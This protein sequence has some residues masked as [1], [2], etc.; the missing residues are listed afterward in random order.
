MHKMHK[1][2]TLVAVLALLGSALAQTITFATWGG[3][4]DLDIYEEL[5]ADFEAANPGVTV[6]VNHIPSAGDYEQNLATLIAAGNAPDVFFINNISMPGFA[7]QGAFMS[8]EDRAAEFDLD[9]FFPGHLDAFR[10]EGELIVVPRDISNLV[11]F[12][13]AD[14][15]REAGLEEPGD[16]WTREDFLDAARELT[17][18]QD[19]DGNPDQFGFGFS[20]FW[21]FWQPWVWSAGGSFFAEDHSAFT[22]NEGA[23]LEG[24]EFYA[25]L[26]CDENVAPTAAQAADRAA[27]SMF[28]DGDAAMIVDGRWRVAP[29]NASEAVAFE[30]DVVQFPAGPAGSVVDADGSGWGISS[31]SSNP[32]LAWSFIEHVASPEAMTRFTEAGLIIP[33][34]RS[35]GITEAFVQPDV[36]PANDM[37]FIEANETAL[38]TETFEGWGEFVSLLNE[39][40]SEVWLCNASVAEGLGMVEDD[41]DDL[42]AEYR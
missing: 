37:A 17:I 33:A 11:L 25:G 10:Y 22:L 29:L 19:G 12:Y 40:M 15:F 18:D 9:D 41:I 1:L 26:R 24:L 14:M 27:A 42:L 35:V 23:A 16:G 32:D 7:A 4:E 28:A 36:P 21:L 5:I 8:L 38:P 39:G 2:L 6:T 13:N 3:T 30:W 34:R 20:T 31:T